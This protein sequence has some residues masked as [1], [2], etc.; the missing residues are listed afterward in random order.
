[1]K[2]LRMVFAAALAVWLP[3]RR[4]RLKTP[5]RG[6]HRHRSCG[7]RARAAIRKAGPRG[8]LRIARSVPDKAEAR[9]GHRRRARSAKSREPPLR[10]SRRAGCT[11]ERRAGQWRHGDLSGKIIIDITNAFAPVAIASW[12]WSWTHRAASDPVLGTA[13]QGC[14]GIQ[15][16]ERHGHGKPG[17]RRRPVTVPL[18]GDDTAAK[19]RVAEIVRGMGFETADVG[20]IRHARWLEGMTILYLTPVMSGRAQDSFEFYFR[21]RSRS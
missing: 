10:H 17:N 18:A 13:V 3:R 12:P 6:H 14:E 8:Y 20:P 16:H 1:M 2:Q 21:P 11:L 7:Q 9:G 4:F 15:C 19:A 5:K